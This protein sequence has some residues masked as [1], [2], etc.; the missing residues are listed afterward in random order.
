MSNMPNPSPNHQTPRAQT[1]MATMAGF[2]V[3]RK[4]MPSPMHSW[5]APKKKFHTPASGRMKCARFVMDQ[6]T[7]AGW[8][9][10]MGS[11]MVLTRS[12]PN[13]RGWNC[14]PAS[15][16]HRHPSAIWTALTLRCR[17]SAASV[18]GSSAVTALWCSSS[19]TPSSVSGLPRLR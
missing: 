18:I 16:I 10:A 12:E 7:G 5:S 4:N 6:A 11:I 1:A 3:R 15:R 2:T 17:R 8:P 9:W 13:M 19:I 14:S